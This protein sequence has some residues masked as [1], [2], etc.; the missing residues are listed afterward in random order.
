MCVCVCV[1]VS[2]SVSVTHALAKLRVLARAVCACTCVCV[3]VLETVP[4]SMTAYMGM[5]RVHESVCLYL[6]DPINHKRYQE[7]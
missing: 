6:A 2:E 7:N 1:C 4:V 3:R 5:M